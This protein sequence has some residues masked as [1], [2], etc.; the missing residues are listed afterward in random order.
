MKTKYDN[1]AYDPK[2]DAYYNKETG[3]WIE[4]ACKDKSCHFCKNRPK[5]HHTPTAEANHQTKSK[6]GARSSNQRKNVR[7]T[8]KAR[9]QKKK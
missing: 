5:R 8:V 2:H 3:F 1:S 7:G 6:R 4:R 9:L